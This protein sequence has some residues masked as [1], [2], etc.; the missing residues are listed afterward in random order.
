MRSSW[1]KRLFD[2]RAALLYT[3]RW[4]GIVAGLLFA[5]W[6]ASGIV[7]M[8]ARMPA[9]APEERLA[10]L[11]P[12]DLSTVTIA[13]A[14]AARIGAARGTNLQ[15][16]M[17]GRRPAYRLGGRGG[18][19]GQ[20]VYAD[21][22]EAF[23]GLSEA[24]ARDAARRYEPGYSGPLREE[25]RLTEPD[26]WTL[27]ARALMPMRRFALDDTAATRLYVSDASG[28]VVLR[29][30]RRERLLAYLGPVI[31]WV[32]FTP[33]RRN[34]PLWSE[35][36]IWSSVA[37][38]VMC[39]AGLVWGVLRFS[40]SARFNLKGAR[41]RSPYLGWM[42][43]HHYTGLVFGL[44]T[45]T[46]TYS[47]LLS[48]GPFGWF[49]PSA[50]PRGRRPPA[51]A[52]ESLTS[53]SL[54][55]MRAAFATL[56]RDFPPKQ[57]DLTQVRGRL[58]WAADRPPGPDD[59]D[60]WRSPSLLPRAPRPRLER[61]YVAASAPEEGTFDRFPS[62]LMLELARAQMPDVPVEDSTWL[63][64]YDG[65][66]YDSRGSLPL[67]VL[68][69]RYADEA[70]TW[71]YVDPS[72][73]AVVDRSQRI[74]RVQRWLYQGLHSLDFPFL[75][76]RRP[77]WDFTVIALSLGGLALSLTSITDA[78]HRLKGHAARLTRRLRRS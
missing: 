44:V 43:W 47:G 19:G 51:T 72:R 45:L 77:L 53:V 8:Y 34:G 40:P 75:Y 4:L 63:D 60:R 30:T 5:A 20:V 46:W 49:E 9:L 78:W 76:Y 59:A 16:F 35:V 52:S 37:G 27:Q 32:Y 66:Y 69:V 2:W 55:R 50:G 11:D 62:P 13:P 24:A 57:L 39:I 68:R 22:G 14:D 6:F 26:Q 10:R 15:L 7:M 64:G 74:T 21:T 28:E 17:L 56:S 61:R 73:G 54:E 38:C 12:L 23:A 58:F 29:T 33:L 41:Q 25:A 36:I 71:L 3:H 31:H 18:R 48:M 67:P 70:Y 1:V 42:K 65:Y